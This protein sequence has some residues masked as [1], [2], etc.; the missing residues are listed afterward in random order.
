VINIYELR[1]GDRHILAANE[2]IIY[3]SCE[4][5]VDI[6]WLQDKNRFILAVSR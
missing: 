3:I 5:K 1:V 4:L 6:Y 2:C